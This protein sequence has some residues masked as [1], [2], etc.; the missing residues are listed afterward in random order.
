MLFSTQK[1]RYGWIGLWAVLFCLG[2]GLIIWSIWPREA[3]YVEYTAP[4][5][6][7]S[8]NTNTPRVP[9]PSTTSSATSLQTATEGLSVVDPAVDDIPV[10]VSVVRDDQE[11][12]EA[13]R[14]STGTSLSS[15]GDVWSPKSGW[16]E[17]YQP[18]GYP[19]PGVLATRPAVIGG[20]VAYSGKPDVFANLEQVEVG[21]IVQVTYQ[22]GV[23]YKFQVGKIAVADKEAMRTE[24]SIWGEGPESRTVV[25]MTCDDG[26]GFGPDGHRRDNRAVWATMIE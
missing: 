16:A 8:T 2:A 4:V 7:T 6:S 9:V 11:I 21:D 24:Q 19:R 23:E 5:P 22:S 26:S 17:W 3:E 15:G 18:D 10:E 20:H 12:V 13:V 1:Y 14:L 25:L